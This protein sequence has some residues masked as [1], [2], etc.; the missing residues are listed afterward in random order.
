MF[1][2]EVQEVELL[3]VNEEKSNVS[4]SNLEKE[5]K[6][7]NLAN[8][9][10]QLCFSGSCVFCNALFSYIHCSVSKMDTWKGFSPLQFCSYVFS[11]FASR[12]K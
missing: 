2:W 3:I 10:L 7:L 1:N 11:A 4:R 9:Y 12:I 6:I 5:K 8:H